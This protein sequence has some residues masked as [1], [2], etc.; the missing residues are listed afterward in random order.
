[1]KIAA[2]IPESSLS[3]LLSVESGTF[4]ILHFLTFSHLFCPVNLFEMLQIY[5]IVRTGVFSEEEL[6]QLIEGNVMIN[7]SRQLENRFQ[8]SFE[9]ASDF[10]IV[11]IL[12]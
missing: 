3:L 4:V 8:A 10:I 5:L 2:V 7:G 12:L 1:M 6:L 11:F 9:Q